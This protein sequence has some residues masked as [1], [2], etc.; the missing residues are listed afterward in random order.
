MYTGPQLNKARVSCW[1]GRPYSWRTDPNIESQQSALTQ[2]HKRATRNKIT[3]QCTA[4]ITG[5][6]DGVSQVIVVCESVYKCLTVI[7]IIVL[8][9]VGGHQYFQNSFLD[10][11]V[12]RS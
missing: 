10:K 9:I 7:N 11:Q 1:F 6:L 12:S 4:N 2:S 3:K 5:S 8:E